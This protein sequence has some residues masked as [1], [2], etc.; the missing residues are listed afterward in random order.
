M[1]LGRET[2]ER[3]ATR[4]LLALALL[5]T[6]LV[7]CGGS[8]LHRTTSLA[9]AA[10]RVAPT[11]SSHFILVVLEN[12]ELDEVTGQDGLAHLQQ[13]IQQGTLASDYYA[14]TH[15]SLPNYI[16]LLAGDTRGITSD[17]TECQASGTTLID[18]LESAHIGWRAY[19]EDLPQPC[20]TGASA[21]GYVK[22]H[23]P[24]MYFPQIASNPTRC[25]QVV[26]LT[27]LQDDIRSDQL[28][29]FVWISPNLC[30]DG[31]D[32]P[33]QSVDV[34]LAQL[35]PTLTANLGSRGVLAVVW[36]EGTSHSGCCSRAS[37]GRVALVLAGRPVR[38]RYRLTTAADHYS[39]LA[40]IEQAFGLRRLGGAACRCTASLNRA[41]K[42]GR[43]P[44]LRT[45]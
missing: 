10:K 40:V 13:L 27:Q 39:L 5:G 20:Y 26:P 6:L 2:R 30:N 3:S 31:H 12:R 4:I 44:R 14:I 28:P 25:H 17:C 33:N 22:R 19:M 41:F 24:F 21:K 37:G 32:C 36:D 7:A 43:P 16:A 15:P 1:L 38:A 34:F 29:P 11:P 8:T 23:D 9:S 35:L 42:S 18:Q 45:G